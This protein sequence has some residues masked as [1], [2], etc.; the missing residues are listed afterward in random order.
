MVE[1]HGLYAH[2]H[3]AAERF[4]D[5]LENSGCNDAEQ[6]QCEAIEEAQELYEIYRR[7]EK[8]FPQEYREYLEAIDRDGPPEPEP[9]PEIVG[10]PT[11]EVSEPVGRPTETVRL[12]RALTLESV[13]L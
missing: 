5:Y 7:G 6:R 12:T 4:A 2:P 13:P 11:E 8:S 1:E 9:T 10:R 3:D